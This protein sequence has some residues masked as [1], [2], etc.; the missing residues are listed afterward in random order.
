M[1]KFVAVIIIN[2]MLLCPYFVFIDTSLSKH[3]DMF[4]DFGFRLRQARSKLGGLDTSILHHVFL[5]LFIMFLSIIML[6][7]VILMPFLS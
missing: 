6:F 4:F 5:L 1:F 3:E 2:M 7:G